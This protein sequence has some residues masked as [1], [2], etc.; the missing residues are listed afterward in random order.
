MA[1]NNNKE[2]YFWVSYSDLMTSLFF[3]ML[4]LFVLV[5]VLL[6]NKVL[7]VEKERIR[8]EEAH[9]ATQEQVDKI[10]EIQKSVEN[11]NQRYFTY[12]ERYKK[13]IFK[14]EVRYP[15][16]DFEINNITDQSLL[17][18]IVEAG[19]DIQSLIQKF[20]RED[21]IQY[22]VVLEGQAS[23]DNYHLDDYHNNNVL[24][25]L[26]A[27]KLKEFWESHGIELDNFENCEILV[28]GSGEGGVP[29]NY[30]NERYNQRFLIHII[31]KTG[32]I[33]NES[34]NNG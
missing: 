19:K 20:S 16:G 3:V 7:E 6:H 31:P 27:L 25:Y 24:S 14:L 30:I 5:I 13:H 17:N 34:N 22:L 28:S 15:A 32:V 4:V 9:Q 23:K 8:A 33:G 18:G 26:R 12:N 10:N 11:I 21:N 2:S 29:R 1:K